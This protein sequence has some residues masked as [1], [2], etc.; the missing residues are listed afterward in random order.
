VEG[1]A[2]KVDQSIANNVYMIEPK[3]GIEQI[4]GVGLECVTT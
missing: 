1:E 2:D 3:H 4:K